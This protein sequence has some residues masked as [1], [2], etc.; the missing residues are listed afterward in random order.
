MR[1]QD[2]ARIAQMAPALKKLVVLSTDGLMLE[3]WSATGSDGE[4]VAALLG[5]LLQAGRQAAQAD[6]AIDQPD[7]ISIETSEALLF[8]CPLGSELAGG[9]VFDRTTTLG[10]AR[11]QIRDMVLE[12]DKLA[13]GTEVRTSKPGPAIP[14]PVAGHEPT[15][16]SAPPIPTPPTSIPAS[17]PI[18]PATPIPAARTPSVAAP[19]PPSDPS[20]RPRAVRL[21]EFLHRY[22]PDPHVSLLRLSL[23][24]GIALEKLDRPDLLTHEQVESM[25]ASVRDIIGQEQL[26]I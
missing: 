5:A 1:R 9:F 17:V 10:L 7:L 23:R 22:A 21:L 4:S 26:G 18:A 8:V 2:V 12:L 3:H 15:I 24:T 16:P 14:I 19:P 11:I 13:P 6:S 20:G 25:A